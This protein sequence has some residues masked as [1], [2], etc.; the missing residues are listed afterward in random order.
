V[1]TPYRGS[2]GRAAL[3]PAGGMSEKERKFPGALT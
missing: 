1:G 3:G 2:R